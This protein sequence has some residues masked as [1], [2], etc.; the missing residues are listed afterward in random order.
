MKGYY[1]PEFSV[2]ETRNE[3]HG[4]PLATPLLSESNLIEISNRLIEAQKKLAAESIFKI[5]DWID[6]A[7]RC[8]ADPADP[9]RQ[10]AESIL[11]IITGDSREMV[12]FTLDDLL[13]HLTRPVLLQLLE[14]E[15]GD[16]TLLDQFRPKTKGVGFTRAF[17][18]RLTVHIL[19]GNLAGTAVFSLVCSL[20]AKSAGLA[21]VS[22]EE[23]LLPVLF[24]RSLEKIRPDLAQSLAVLTWENS[25]VDLTRAVFQ[26]ADLAIIY[27]GD[28]TIET[29]RK[30]IPPST[31]AIFHGNRLSLGV[32]A[33][34]SI[35]KDRAEQAA[36][37]IA[38]FDQ[39]GCLSPHLY[40][41]EEGG[42]VSPVEFA[43]WLAQALYVASYQ[44]PKGVT[45][46][47]EAAQIQQLRGAIPLKGGKVFPSP[48]GVDWTV[49]YDPD[50]QFS[51]SPLART[52]WIKPVADLSE[53]AGYLESI[54]PYLQ[55]VGIA[56]PQERQAEV[57][58]SLAR[59]GVN[60]ICAIG[61][62]QKP[63]LTWHHD[64]RFRLLDLLRFV[65][66]E[67]T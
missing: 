31:R 39:R 25:A 48:S 45:S 49:L 66:W 50:P 7:A 13:R 43:Q 14:A 53:I 23:F 47:A 32:I 16:P 12:R 33:R 22:R 54:R 24:A 5:V 18:P 51:I 35:N 44:L 3:E 58:L 27:G 15:V 1:L 40:Y 67:N 9:I 21:K 11:P 55:A 37:D 56:I 26:K 36:T 60:R 10:E 28:E 59:M 17:G 46:S 29:L 8:W 30:E 52:I 20:L 38:L 2:V 63:P 19:P 34:E 4:V 57:I 61:K 6:A 42:A 41:V 64:G 65:D 62:M